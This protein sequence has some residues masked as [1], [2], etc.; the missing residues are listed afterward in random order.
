MSKFNPVL[1]RYLI[2]KYLSNY[3]YVFDPF[4]GFSGRLLGT[5]SCNKHYIRQDLNENAVDESNQIIRFLDA[6]ENAEITVKDILQS[7]GKYECLLTCPL[8]YT[9]EIYNKETEF[10][11]CDEW[12]TECLQR[13]NCNRYVFVVDQTF[14]YKNHV[15][16]EIKHTSHLTKTKEQ[17]VVI[18]NEIRV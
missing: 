14:K 6:A 17:V 11:T 1:A 9:K 13:F 7:H 3:N 2:L 18:D 10:K 12:I 8:Y 16:E 5:L 4:S 15:T